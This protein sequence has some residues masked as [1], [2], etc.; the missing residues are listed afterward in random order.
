MVRLD[1]F[2]PEQKR[3]YVVATLVIGLVLSTLTL[4]LRIWARIVVIKKL[5]LE[6]WFMIAGLILSYGAVALTLWGA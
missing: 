5:R 1:N 2:T 4:V 3:Q 6:D